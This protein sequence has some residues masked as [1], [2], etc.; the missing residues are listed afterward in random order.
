M[1]ALPRTAR[2][3]PKFAQDFI[4]LFAGIERRLKDSGQIKRGKRIAEADWIT[5]SDA[6]GSNFFV[7]IQ[8]SGKA[9]SLIAEPPRTRMAAGLVF[10]PENP[11]PLE[12]VQDLF[13][14]GVCRVR[15]NIVHGEKF[16]VSGSGWERDEI[17]TRQAHWV[18]LR[19][20]KT[21][22]Q[23]GQVFKQPQTG[24]AAPAAGAAK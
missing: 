3:W 19:A 20:M 15:N 17:L 14:R 9:N 21:A 2:N 23:S 4:A 16:D 11:F 8:R 7:E 24:T 1:N 12:N 6:L 22:A 10:S 18:L 5:F 13:L